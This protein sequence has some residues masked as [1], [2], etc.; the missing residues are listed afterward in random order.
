LIRVDWFQELL[1]IAHEVEVKKDKEEKRILR[2]LDEKFPSKHEAPT[3][4]TWIQEM[5]AGLYEE[6]SDNEDVGDVTK[7]SNNPP[8]RRENKKTVA[9]R[10]KEKRVRELVSLF[11]RL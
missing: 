5:S 8:V 6:A 9:Q 10:N 7:I 11:K 2:S 4:Q 3:H 1:H